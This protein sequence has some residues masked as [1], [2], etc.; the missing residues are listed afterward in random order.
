MN[1]NFKDP[2]KSLDFKYL[3]KKMLDTWLPNQI[4]TKSDQLSMAHGLETRVPFLDKRILNLVLNIPEKLL[5]DQNNNKIVFR[6]VLKNSGFKNF[7]RPKKAF[8]VSLS[9]QYK[10]NL[11]ILCKEFLN[12]KYQK[13][14][15]IFKKSF[16]DHCIYNMNKGEFVAAK[17]IVMI[18]IIHRWMDL[19]FKI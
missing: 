6:K 8:Y 16:F 12:D 2:V 17:R 11:K 7:D 1:D 3:Q 19:Y 4:C 18:S 9:N 14:Y 10:N 5:S 13:K 15:D